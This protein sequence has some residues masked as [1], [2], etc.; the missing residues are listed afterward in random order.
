MRIDRLDRWL[1][2]CLIGL[3]AIWLWLV[4]TYIPGARG[5][6]EP[7]PRAFPVLLGFVLLG[8]GSLTTLSAFLSEKAKREAEALIVTQREA[9][10]ASGTFG[11]L[12]LYAFMLEKLGFL[13]A[14]PIAVALTMF[15]ILRMRN[16]ILV[17][18]LATGLTVA[19]WMFFAMLLETP[20]PRGLWLM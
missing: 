1:G 18:S 7:G 19:C 14:T 9:L 4:Y 11:V 2:P 8:L 5:E 3:A 20:L 16:W 12:I 13:I 6:G 17:L 10:I 15:G